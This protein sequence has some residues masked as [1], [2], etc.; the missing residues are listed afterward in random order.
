MLFQKWIYSY[1]VFILCVE[2]WESATVPKL[3]AFGTWAFKRMPKAF[4]MEHVTYEV[5]INNIF[6]TSRRE[7]KKNVFYEVMYLP[8]KSSCR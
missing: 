8:M 7:L 2:A 4:W 5:S 1:F 3:E 6:V